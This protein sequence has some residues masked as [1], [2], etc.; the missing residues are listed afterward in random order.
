MKR[1]EIDCDVAVVGAGPAGLALATAL[2]RRGVERVLVLERESQAGGIPRHCGHP[3]FGM[4]EFGRVLTGPGY[5]RRLAARAEDAGVQIA[6]AHTT[7]A[8][9]RGPQLVVSSP[10]GMLDVTARRVALATGVRETPRAARLVSG[11][12]PL[13]VMTT[14]ALQS[15][16]YLKGRLPFRR[17]VIVGSELVSFS[18]I[19]TCRHLGARPVA[20]VEDR[21]RI[22]AWRAAALLPRALGITLAT[23]TRLDRIEG[24]ERVEAVWTVDELGRRRRIDCD[25]VVFSGRFVSESTLARSSHLVLDP[26]TGGPALDQDGRCSDPDFF[27]VGNMTHPADSAG[28]CWREGVRLAGIIARDLQS[29]PRPE[30]REVAVVA[31]DPAIRYV[32]PQR[33]SLPATG[34]DGCRLTIRFSRAVRGRLMIAAGSTILAARSVNG[35]PERR[36]LV[37]VPAEKLHAVSSPVTVAIHP[38]HTA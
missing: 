23:G 19:L 21:Q 35:L 8:I 30:A 37:T 1:R 3:P 18:A 5:A 24:G 28:S 20:M 17:P 10:D 15:M 9:R 26:G 2:R 38:G 13:G 25:G 7:V 11:P 16:V 34:R 32:T 33:L 12:R 22:T 14:G 36:S 31:R 6:L 29:E 4:R 27:A